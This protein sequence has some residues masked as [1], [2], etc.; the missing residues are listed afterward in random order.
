VE[1][2]VVTPGSDPSRRFSSDLLAGLDEPVGRYFSHAISEGAPLSYG[3]RMAMRGRIK[4]GL[5][6]PFTAEQTVDG[7][8]F[9]WR[10][11]VGRGPLTPLRVVDRYAEA[12]GSTEGR[13]LGRA[14]LFEA[15][16]INTARSAATRA[17]IESVVFAPP[18]VL[19]RRGVA[20]RA[21]TENIIVARFD[22]PPERPEVRVRIDEHGAIRTVSALRW[23]NAGEKT[24][25]YIPCG[26]EI[27]AERRFGDLV[28]PSSIS[29]GWW[30]DT[31]RYAPFFKA[32]I[33]AV[34]QY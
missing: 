27:H 10:A 25:Q 4:V 5:W 29:V 2:P 24:F 6:L 31:P 15:E 32:Q 13:L 12:V 11:R 7:R 28:L 3:V 33:E 20:W 34:S 8:S 19:P 26:G 18:G 17:A 1:Q 16:D 14:T 9:T 22:L 23:G 30:F 21:E